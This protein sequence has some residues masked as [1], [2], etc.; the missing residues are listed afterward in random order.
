[1]GDPIYD[2]D[3]GDDNRYLSKRSI[4]EQREAIRD[5]VREAQ[6]AEDE[7][8]TPGAFGPGYIFNPAVFKE[9]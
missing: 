9:D 4:S 7:D 8:V 2:D 5:Q 1:M 3:P 6:E